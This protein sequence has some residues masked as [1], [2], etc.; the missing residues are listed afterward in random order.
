MEEEKELRRHAERVNLDPKVL[1]TKL[2]Q[3]WGRVTL[4]NCYQLFVQL[5]SKKLKN[6][7]IEFQN[8]AKAAKEYLTNAGPEPKTP[9][10]NPEVQ[11][12]IDC[13]DE[14]YT[15]MCDEV[16][17]KS[18]M[19]EDKPEADLLTLYFSATDLLPRNSMR[20]LVANANNAL[21]SMA[22]AEKMLAS[23]ELLTA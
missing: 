17:I 20:N 18:S 22:G 3:M 19:W 12:L 7:S 9:H 1:E 2:D 4:Y 14:E 15:Q 8:N 16:T 23:C 11:K 21:K 6:P 13:T 5:T 10:P